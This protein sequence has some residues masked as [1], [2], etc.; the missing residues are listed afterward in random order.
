VV[1]PSLPEKTLQVITGYPAEQAMLARISADNPAIAERFEVFLNGVELANG[2]CE[3]RDAEE[4]AGRFAADNSR[5]GALNR[6][7]HA[8]DTQLLAALEHGLPQCSGVAVGLDRVLM[9]TTEQR[10]LRDTLSFPPGQ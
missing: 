8:A 4:Q 3:L 10:S 6:V 9:L 7:I 5:R 1:V 2:F